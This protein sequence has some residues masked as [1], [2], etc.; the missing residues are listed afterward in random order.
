[1]N[2]GIKPVVPILGRYF[3]ENYHKVNKYGA[4]TLNDLENLSYHIYNDI[5]AK[6]EL[7]QEQF[8]LWLAK[9]VW[10]I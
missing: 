10:I 2:S 9:Q 6:N 3:K 4:R 1:M 7:C 8:T 5:Q